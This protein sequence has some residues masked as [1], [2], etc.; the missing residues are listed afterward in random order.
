MNSKIEISHE[1]SVE[2]FLTLRQMVNFQPLQDD[3]AKCI[4]KHTTYIAVARCEG[5]CV[6]LPVCC[7]IMVQMPILQMLL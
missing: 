4:L 1:L 5:R 2:E 6:A 7:L 3:Q